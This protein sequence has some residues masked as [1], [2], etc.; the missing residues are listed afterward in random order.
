G[1]GFAVAVDLRSAREHGVASLGAGDAPAP[2]A[3]SDP[4]AASVPDR[5]ATWKRKLLDLTLRNGLISY[6]ERSQSLPLQTTSLAHLEDLLA[7][8]ESFQLVP[9]AD[10]DDALQVDAALAQGRLHVALSAKELDKRALKAFREAKSSLEETGANT[11]Y[12]ALGFL[13]WF[14]TEHSETPRRAPILLLSAELQRPGVGKGFRLALSDEDPYLNV[15]LLEKL[16][17]DFP[18][19][20]TSE[21]YE[22]PED[23]SGLDV[24]RIFERYRRAIRGRPRWEVVEEAHAAP[25]SFSKFL[26]WRDLEEH[27]ELL[28]ENRVVQHLALG[29]G[30]G[31]AFEAAGELPAPETLDTARRAQDL[32]CPRDADSSQLVAI[33]ASNDG[34]SFV[35]QGPPGTGKSQTITNMIAHCLGHG[36]RVL[37]V[38]EKMAALNVVH[39][40]LRQAGLAPF[41]LEI[42]STKSS[43]KAILAQLEEAFHAA[44]TQAPAEW[45]R[46]ATQLEALRA[47]LN[48]YAHELHDPRPLGITV[49]RATAR[50]IELRGAPKLR[51]PPALFR[52]PSP[53]G[54]ARLTELAD[55]LQAALEAVGAPGEH[56][57]AAVRRAA[58]TS[59]LS[60]DARELGER[61]V[62]AGERVREAARALGSLAPPEVLAGLSRAALGRV[63]QLAGLLL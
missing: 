31:E 52:A 13:Q 33:H 15:T 16:K 50:L 24:P 9:K 7:A 58:W 17:L 20:D 25:F 18:D 11:F 10:G 49:F 57:L 56:P 6:R 29:T 44:S 2:P 47:Q 35:L 37:F 32:F 59:T 27:T 54:Y 42:H 5:V 55:Q 40:R 38:S 21:L 19:V 41:C 4:D 3:A 62:A 48:A 39:D 8:G 30:R 60:E 1:E 34:R 14:E 26:M 36:R 12:L 46:Q 45:E 51:L 43:K 23:D 53:E 63:A 61:V 28:L 22:L